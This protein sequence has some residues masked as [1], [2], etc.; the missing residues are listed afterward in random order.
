MRRPDTTEPTTSADEGEETRV[1][2]PVP[3]LAEAEPERC[4]DVAESGH[5][6]DEDDDEEDLQELDEDEEPA[7][8]EELVARQHARRRRVA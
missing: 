8:L 2:A 6:D 3:A 1:I 7:D 4:D 5:D